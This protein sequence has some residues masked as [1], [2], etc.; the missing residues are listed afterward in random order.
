[1]KF[2]RD[3]PRNVLI[4][5]QLAGAILAPAFIFTIGP[6]IVAALNS[7]GFVFNLG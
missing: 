1:M 6:S 2:D 3:D 7:L 4:W 5:S